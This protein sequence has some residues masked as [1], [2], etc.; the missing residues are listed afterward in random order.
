MMNSGHSHRHDEPAAECLARSVADTLAEEP[1]LEAVT[2]DAAQKKISVAT[3]GRANVE[4]LTQKISAKIQSAQ[5]STA[6]QSCGLFTGQPECDVCATPLSTAELNRITIQHSGDVTTIARVTCPTAPKFWRWRDLPFPRLEVKTMEIHDDDEHDH[7]ADE[8]KWQL[9]LA[10]VCGVFG[11]LGGVRRADNLQSF[12]L[13]HRVS[14]RRI[15][16]GRGSLGTPAEN[17]SSTCIS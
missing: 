3:M 5:N 9:A 16:P 12:C 15:F 2:I 4:K 10:V 6:S 1:T 17:A 7:H 11:L 13:L 14:R 8:W